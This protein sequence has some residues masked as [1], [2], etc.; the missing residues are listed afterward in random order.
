MRYEEQDIDQKREQSHQQRRQEQ[1]EESQEKARRMGRGV[2]VGCG[3][4]AETNEGQESGDGVDDQDR[5]ERLA[6]ARGE[7]EI[8]AG[9]VYIACREA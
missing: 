4:Q 2:E 8:G 6:G 7:V 3:R 5:R 9:A 1:D